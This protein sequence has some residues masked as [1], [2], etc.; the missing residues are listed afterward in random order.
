MT[1]QDSHGLGLRFRLVG[2]K[3]GGEEIVLAVGMS[4]EEAKRSKSGIDALR[5]Y[6]R[7]RI[8]PDSDPKPNPR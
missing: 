7:T 2:I 1:E 6:A 5:E 3:K 4:L 8:E